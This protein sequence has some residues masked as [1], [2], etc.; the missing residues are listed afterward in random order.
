VFGLA[1]ALLLR[2][3]IRREEQA[4]DAD[5]TDSRDREALQAQ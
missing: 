1:N 5:G 2:D 4:L 3:R